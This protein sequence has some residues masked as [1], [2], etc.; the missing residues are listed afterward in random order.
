MLRFQIALAIILVG[1]VAFVACER[2]QQMLDPADMTDPGTD[3]PMDMT[4]DMMDMTMYTSSTTLDAPTMTAAEAKA[5]MNPGGTGAAHVG[6]T[7]RTVYFNEVGAMANMAGT[8]PYPA[9][10]MI[11]KK[12]MD[13]TETF[14]KQVVTM[15]KTDDAMYA[16]HNGW[17]YGVAQRDS[18]TDELMMPHQLAVDMAQGCHD[19]HMAAGAD[20]DSVFV[21]LP[22]KDDMTGDGTDAGSTDAGGTDAG[23]TDAGSTDAGGTD[24]GGTDAG[25]TDAGGTDAG[26]TD[27][28]GTDAG[29][30]DAGD[31]NGANG[32][33]NANG[34]GAQ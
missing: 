11:L 19:C 34:N 14:V 28:G 18:E 17:I 22:M 6:K 8:V 20:R 9:G 21:S 12:V 25:S 3:K 32:A 10:T 2:G 23:S 15:T 30:T 4:M 27:A 1:C 33:G 26:S 7:T 29:G 16:A 24:A 31:T 13:D 5:A